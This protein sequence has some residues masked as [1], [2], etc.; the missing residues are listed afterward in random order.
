MIYLKMT[1]DF[2]KYAEVT[3]K[4]E[5]TLWSFDNGGWHFISLTLR[6]FSVV[7]TEM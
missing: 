2:S 4:S 7:R 1:R 6:T 5:A 3:V